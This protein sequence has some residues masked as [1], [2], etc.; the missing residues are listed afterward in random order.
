MNKLLIVTETYSL[1][2]KNLQSIRFRVTDIIKFSSRITLR[3]FRLGLISPVE[4]RDFLFD[5]LEFN[6]HLSGLDSSLL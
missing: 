5:P 3:K 2:V 1:F 4:K 6:P